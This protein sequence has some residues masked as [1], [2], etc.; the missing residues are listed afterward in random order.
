MD[1]HTYTQYQKL[2]TYIYMCELLLEYRF[3]SVNICVS[4]T[5]VSVR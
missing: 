5:R 2:Y 3:W 4:C 1:K